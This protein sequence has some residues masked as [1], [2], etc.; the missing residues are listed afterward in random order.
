MKRILLAVTVLTGLALA[1]P[2]VKR[3]MVTPIEANFKE[4]MDSRQLET[5]ALPRAIYA[6][7][8]GLVVTAD[9]T[10][11]Y[12]PMINPFQLTISKE[13]QE[14]NHA[15][16]LRQLPILRQEMRQAMMS[17]SAVLDPMPMN[18]KI[19]FGVTIGHQTWESMAGI[20]SQIVMQ[21]ERGKLLEAKLGHLP[22]ESAIRVQEQ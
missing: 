12:A 21:G 2:L 8:M 18:E 1:A 19:V 4:R 5:L 17:A 22:V 10:L 9:V 16:R 13:M 6:E 14:K 11:T 7:G 15:S 20:P 3:E